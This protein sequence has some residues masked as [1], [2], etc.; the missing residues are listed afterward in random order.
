M[1]VQIEYCEKFLSFEKAAVNVVFGRRFCGGGGKKIAAFADFPAKNI[2]FFLQQPV[3]SKKQCF[4]RELPYP[5]E[6]VG[7]FCGNLFPMK[8]K[9]LHCWSRDFAAEP[10]QFFLKKLL[11]CGA[12]A[13]GAPELQ[14]GVGTERSNELRLAAKGGHS[15]GKNRAC[16]VFAGPPE[17]LVI[18]GVVIF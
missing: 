1:P 17:F 6:Q 14:S 2:V 7:V 11:V 3:F 4:S 12:V 13:L 16:A 15:D 5:L 8:K 9:S 10:L 18:R